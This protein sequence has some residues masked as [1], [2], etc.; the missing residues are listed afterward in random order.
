MSS[1]HPAPRIAED[2]DAVAR[3]LLGLGWVVRSQ[4]PTAVDQAP[5]LL[6]SR[7][8]FDAT[9]ATVHVLPHHHLELEA[10][11]GVTVD[12]DDLHDLEDLHHHLNHLQ[13]QQQED[14]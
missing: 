14:S 10:H 13:R 6:V 12:L 2:A 4:H 7:T 1:S 5:L 9:A 8:A 11:T 3:Q